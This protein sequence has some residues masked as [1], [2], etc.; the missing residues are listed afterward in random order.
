LR[1]RAP[2]ERAAEGKRAATTRPPARHE[3]QAR[4][5]AI[6]NPPPGAIYLIDPTLRAEFQTLPLRAT[7]S[8]GA[9]RV[10]WR[11][12]GRLV[13]TADADDPVMWPL[14]SGRHR[15]Q[16]RDRAG[17]SDEVAIVVR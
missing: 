2:A 4:P 8:S 7:L 13:G 1:P 9:G 3:E 10:A 5:I 15:V 14:S 6:V 11:V 12:D 17:H 16:A